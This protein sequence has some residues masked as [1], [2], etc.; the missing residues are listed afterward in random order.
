MQKT[1]LSKAL[2]VLLAVLMLLSVFPAVAF[3]EIKTGDDGKEYGTGTPAWDAAGSVKLTKEAAGIPNKTQWELTLGIE[4]KNSPSESYVVLV[5]DNSSS[6]YYDL[7]GNGTAY[8]NTADPGAKYR[9]KTVKETTKEFLEKIWKEDSHLHYSL[10]VFGTDVQKKTDWYGY[11]EMDK[12]FAALD[13]VSQFKDDLTKT[14]VEGQTNIQSGLLAANEL[15]QVESCEGHGKNIILLTDGAPSA[16]Y[17]FLSTDETTLTP[18]KYVIS[19]GNYGGWSGMSGIGSVQSSTY[20]DDHH[21][22]Y[23]N[24][25]AN[26]YTPQA[27]GTLTSTP[28][29]AGYWAYDYSDATGF[30]TTWTFTPST[31]T[32][33]P[34]VNFGHQ[35]VWQARQIRNAGDINIFTIGY[36]LTGSDNKIDGATE[37]Q[38]QNV[39]KAVASDDDFAFFVNINDKA[40]DKL[41]GIYNNIAGKVAAPVQNGIVTDTMSNYVELFMPEGATT[42]AADGSV[43]HTTHT[44]D[45]DLYNEGKADI[46]VSKG[47]AI[48]NPETYTITWYVGTVY[49][50]DP[51]VVMKYKVKLR[52]SVVDAVNN[53]DESALPNNGVN[54][55]TNEKATLAY[56]D[57]KEE[58]QAVDFPKPK[59]SVFYVAHVQR[60][61]LNAENKWDDAKTVGTDI[62]AVAAGFNITGK[63]SAGHLYGGS[64]ENDYVTPIEYGTENPMSF[65]PEAGRTYYIWEVKDQYLLP[66][67]FRAWYTETDGTKMLSNFHIL[68]AVDRLEYYKVGFD[69]TGIIEADYASD[70]WTDNDGTIES[71]V[72]GTVEMTYD[73]TKGRIDLVAVK[74]GYMMFIYNFQDRSD[75][76]EVVKDDGY[77]AI[78]SLPYNTD[79]FATFLTT[80]AS[81]NY[82]FLPYW[83]TLDGV[84]VTGTYRQDCYY[85]G[86]NVVVYKTPELVG[87]TVTLVD[88][89]VSEANIS[90]LSL[91]YAPVF[92]FLATQTAQVTVTVN[93]N[94]KSYPVTA[95]EG[96]DL[97]G[98]VTPAGVEGMVFAGWYTD[99][100]FTTPADLSDVQADTAIYAKYVSD[101]FLRVSYLQT[102]LFFVRNVAFVTAVDGGDYQEVGILVNGEK[103]DVKQNKLLN[104]WLGIRKDS[105]QLVF[106][107][108]SISDYSYGEKITVTAYWVTADG[109]TVYGETKTLTRTWYGIRG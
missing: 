94:G 91:S 25:F 26:T 17:A 79:E 83:I 87:S 23:F 81:N 71:A 78:H 19:A 58:S 98:R 64:F 46:Y 48:Y 68:T 8:A 28:T 6:M 88:N 61:Y 31:A 53:G 3:A 11:N 107:Y 74:K 45:E 14:V 67:A 96:E 52:D 36:W 51:T 2:S 103:I 63:V 100:T 9:M 101:R 55:D 66:Y 77:V 109:T 62:Y 24:G 32:T 104:S 92:T 15:L 13:S 49:E 93:D 76:D 38:A 10:V 70:G 95:E 72:Y 86:T 59:V 12:L 102:G 37:T 16:G 97:T 56:D 84:K 106:G 4:G 108:H 57:Y 54:F 29:Y 34:G 22:S 85:N 1:R 75:S 89:G 5:L 60:K 105:A 43:S 80:T 82:R 50:S 35:T 18:S 21:Y 44:N 30:G 40:D 41:A 27:D 73:R 39:L 99:A 69:V 33:N 20:V 65:T 42:N 47:Y 90:A 7:D